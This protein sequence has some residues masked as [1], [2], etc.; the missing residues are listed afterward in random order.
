MVTIEYSDADHRQF[1]VTTSHRAQALQ[2]GDQVEVLYNRSDPSEARVGIQQGDEAFA[3]GM[4]A[5]V[6]LCDAL[7]CALKG[8]GWI[9]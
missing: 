5:V 1:L 4:L 8:T 9:N 2:L 6:L 3:L 7:Y